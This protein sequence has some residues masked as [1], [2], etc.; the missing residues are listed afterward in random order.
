V[1][2]G[3]RI[4]KEK[5]SETIKALKHCVGAIIGWELGHWLINLLS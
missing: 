5:Y 1:E 4:F 2:K 3:W